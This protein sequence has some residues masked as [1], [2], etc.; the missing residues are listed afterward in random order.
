ML[1]YIYIYS[2]Q[3]GRKCSICDKRQAVPGRPGGPQCGGGADVPGS[4]S[5]RQHQSFS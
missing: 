4:R 1:K 2:G 3:I 5:V